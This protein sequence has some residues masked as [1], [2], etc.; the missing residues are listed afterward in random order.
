MQ[1][2][3]PESHN[4]ACFRQFSGFDGG[5]GAAQGRPAAGIRP[6]SGIQAQDPRIAR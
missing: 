4:C 6:L 5:P 2:N 3:R 1:T